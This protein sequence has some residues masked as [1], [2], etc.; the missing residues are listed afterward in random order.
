MLKITLRIISLFSVSF[1]LISWGSDGHYA[2]N[3]KCTESFPASMNSFL[4][5]ADSLASHGSDADD[6]KSWDPDESMR[7]Y[8]DI[9]AYPEFISSGHIPSTYDSVVSIHGLTFVEDKGILPWAT[10]TMY[11]SLKMSFQQNDW[12]QAMLHASDLGHYV[13]DAHMPLHLTE[14][15][16]GQMTGQYGVHSRYESY[17]VYY[18]L[19]YIT[20]YSGETVNQISNVNS[21]MFNYIYFNQPYV[22]SVLAADDYAQNL[23]G[24]DNTYPYYQA[25]WGETQN[26]TVM[27]FHNASHS[28]AE[29]IYTAWVEAGSPEMTAGISEPDENI[30]CMITYPNPAFSILNCSFYLAS[31]DA[32][33]IFLSDN[34]GQKVFSFINSF[35]KG[36]NNKTIDI[37]RLPVGIYYC[38][39]KSKDISK[40][41]RICITH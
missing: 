28:L 2:I 20:N 16:N 27:L 33:E 34:S 17:M 37:S 4:I 32:A 18:F 26:F 3:H 36:N 41:F 40:S 21:Y 6:R 5:W 38:T 23:V 30:S 31:A 24:N 9:D 29:L 12:H 25:L 19:N 13:G 39:L 8:I 14:N 10:M 7:H 22:D 15:Y 11:D 35:S 1:F